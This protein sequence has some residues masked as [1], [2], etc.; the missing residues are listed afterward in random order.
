LLAYVFWHRPRDLAA[1]DAYEQ[2]HVAFHRSLANSPPVGFRGSAVFQVAELPWPWSAA[3]AQ[4]RLPDDG[5]GGY[6]DWYL[7]DDFTALGILNEAAVGYGHRTAHDAVAHRFGE[8]AGGLY[9][10]VEGART[11]VLAEATLAIWV[12]RPPGSEQRAL[13]ELLGDGMGPEHASLWRR[14]LVLGPAPEYCLL[15]PE[16]ARLEG[17]DGVS[18][19]RLPEGW[20]A[21][22][23]ER[24]VV[25][26]G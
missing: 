18:A 10:L 3:S 6:E 23:F 8:G 20:R 16:P 1:R 14:R 25:F 5:A 7:V 21:V 15:C 13:G 17:P 11:P 12:S 19:T 9:G 22:S 24:V 2:A 26:G 4:A